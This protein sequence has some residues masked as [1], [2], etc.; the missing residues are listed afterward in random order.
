[1]RKMNSYGPDVRKINT[2]MYQVNIYNYVKIQLA[3]L[4][5][6][7]LILMPGK[8]CLIYIT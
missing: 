1:M 8:S 2:V 5:T 4:V 6:V 3:R 7:P